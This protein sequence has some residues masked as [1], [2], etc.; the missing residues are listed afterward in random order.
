M[1]PDV[2]VVLVLSGGN[3]L[4]AFQAG[5][6]EA[7]HAHDLEPEWVV[8]TSVGAINAALIAGSPAERRV[9]TLRSFWQSHVVGP[10]DLTHPWLSPEMETARRST[11][12]AWT[13]VAGR[14]GVFGPI[15]SAKLPGFHD[16][17]SIYETDQLAATLE[18]LV[19]FD[20]LNDGACRFTA[21]A[22]DVTNGEDVVFDTATQSVRPEHI[23]ASAALPVL[24]PPVEVDGRWLVD[25]GLSA[26]LPL[27]P[28]L[29]DPPS[30]PTLCIAVDLLPL[31]GERPRTLGEASGRMQDLMF[32]AQSRRSIAR[33][34][35]AYEGRTDRRV[36]LVRIPYADQGD[37]I[38]G[39]ALDFSGPT[40]AKRWSAGHRAGVRLVD[41]I[42]AGAIAVGAVGLNATV[43]T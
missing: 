13:A 20:R 9:G 6:Y 2:A 39:K 8:G 32:A 29:A 10:L 37:E 40:I 3:A 1:M 4:G 26:N 7:L 14:Y 43:V 17:P 27:D 38:A 15:L 35:A 23:R 11:A 5:L 28:V 25:G 31:S 30:R 12:A 19:D 33:W 18:R 42:N 36:T 41:A 16:A 34:Q 21:T 22:V 24:F